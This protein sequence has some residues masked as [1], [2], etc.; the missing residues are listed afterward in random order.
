MR[1]GGEMFIF[2]III[3]VF[4]LIEIMTNG[5]YLFWEKK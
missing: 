5:Y 2:K 3:V 4:G 1:K